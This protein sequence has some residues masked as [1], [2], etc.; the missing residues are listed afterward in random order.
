[1]KTI[2]KTKPVM[3]TGATG[4][5]A[6]RLIEKLLNDG[7]TVHA[8]V[9]NPD[10]KE[11][12]KYLDSIAKK[13][14]GSIKYFKAD[15]LTDAS[16]EEA[17]QGCELVFHTASPFIV[18]AKD[19]QKD[20]VNPAVKGTANVLL[21]ANKIQTVKRIVLTSSCASIYGDNRDILSYPN[22][23]MTE[24]QW[25]TTSTLKRL[26]YSFS[27][28]Q[29]EKKAWAINK[30]QSRWD[31]VVINPSFVLGP[32]I[33]PFGTSESYNIMK[34]Y[35]DGTMKMGVPR[36]G[37]GCV[38]VR[39]VAEAHFRAGFTPEA[40]G[41]YIVSSESL[42]FF[43]MAQL[44]REKYGNDYPLP[45]RAL[46]KWFVWLIAPAA[47]M[48]RQDVRDNVDIACPADN[49]KSKRELGI[50]YIPIKRSINEF[51]QQLIDNNVLKPAK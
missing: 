9:R 44:L 10:K 33:N 46:P 34:Q 29:A 21:S 43:S 26:P 28:V 2:D 23:I 50:D 19:P 14:K 3:V 13:S 30:Q 47:G 15:L 40:K 41:R 45:K 4:Y 25:N 1:M 36:F 17:M 16:Y 31:L 22:Q 51:F 48:T 5:V 8:A 20:L 35:G 6:G 12:L 11:K 49:T 18:S 38:D 32:G 24:D 39:D 42:N 7:I 37:M 27:K